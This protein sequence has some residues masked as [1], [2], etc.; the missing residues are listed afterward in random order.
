MNRHLTTLLALAAAVLLLPSCRQERYAYLS[1]VPRDQE[2]K[3][4]NNYTTTI[5]PGDLLYIYVHSQLKSSVLPFNEET[6][7]TVQDGLGHS[8]SIETKVKGYLVDDHGSIQFPILGSIHA[9]GL[10]LDQLGHEIEARLKEGRYVKDPVVTVSLMNFRVTVIGEVAKPGLV[11]GMGNRMTVFE[12][13]ALCGDITVD[14]KRTNVM[15]VRQSD[16]NVQLDT[17]DLTSKQ[18]LESPCYYL[19]SGD[20]VY[21]E[22]IDKKKRIATRNDDIPGYAAIAVAIIR[23]ASLFLYRQ[24]RYGE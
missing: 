17:V 7:Q 18:V 21:V 13:L 15:V 14:G 19:H 4:V 9:S 11:R 1:D 3:I 24:T 8:A 10:T 2:M 6:R 23:T 16:S 22:P 20:I 12:A 5:F